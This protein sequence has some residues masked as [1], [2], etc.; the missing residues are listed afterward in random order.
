MN[1][2]KQKMAL[3]HLTSN[4]HT[5]IS[6]EHFF[7]IFINPSIE[8]EKWT[9]ICAHFYDACCIFSLFKI[10][11]R[12][13]KSH[14]YL[15]DVLTHISA[16]TTGVSCFFPALLN[17]RLK[18]YI[19]SIRK[20]SIIRTYYKSFSSVASKILCCDKCMQFIELGN[21]F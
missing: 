1:A 15:A 12:E 6:L 3:Q 11:P 8:F 4:R 2:T 5:Y 17:S 10:Q 13:K 19:C 20:E 16:I 7:S 18:C 9:K 14:F 21:I